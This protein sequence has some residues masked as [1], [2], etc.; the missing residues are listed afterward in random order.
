M[1]RRG[2]LWALFAVATVG[3]TGETRAQVNPAKPFQI[4]TFPDFLNPTARDFFMDAMREL[5][6]IEGRDFVILPSG[7]QL[8]E[9]GLDEAAKRV[10]VDKP[11]LLLTVNTATTLAVHRAT[12][13]IPIVAISFGYPVEAGIAH[14]LARPGKNVTGHSAYAG[15]E[16]WGKLLQLLHDV[17]PGTKRISV[18]WTYVPPLFPREEIEPA[19]AELRNAARSLGLTL[20][21]AEAA[22]SD[23]VADTLMNIEAERPDALLPTSSLALKLRPIVMEFA[24]KRLLPTITDVLWGDIEPYS[25]LLDHGVSWLAQTRAAVNNVVTILKGAKP[26]D[27]PIQQ[28]A[29]FYLRVNLKTASA[30]ELTV[31]PSILARAD[32]VIE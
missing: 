5:D 30:I 19:Y 17:K 20:H 26:G 9:P 7:F 12:P 29:N 15:T 10:V 6:W 18:L 14:S 1:N 21:I 22:S 28:P 23:Q 3:G 31:P 16:I 27:L 13:S 32:R 2:A 11:D 4:A 8:G 24:V 25:P